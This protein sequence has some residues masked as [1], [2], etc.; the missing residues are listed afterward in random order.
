LAHL[1]DGMIIRTTAAA[2]LCGVTRSTLWRWTLEDARVYRC[3]FKP[4]W[5]IVE[6]LAEI[7]LCQ[8]PPAHVTLLTPTEPVRRQA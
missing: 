7:G 2:K 6:R 1:E 4:G 3:L 5:Y 8:P